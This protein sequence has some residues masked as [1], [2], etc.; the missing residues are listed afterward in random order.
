MYSGKCCKL[1]IWDLSRSVLT[2]Y[3]HSNRGKVS[4]F[5]RRNLIICG[6]S[7]VFFLFIIQVVYF[8][9]KYWVVQGF[10]LLS[11]LNVSLGV[12][13]KLIEIYKLYKLKSI[14]FEFYYCVKTKI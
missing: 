11:K 2:A 9:S 6:F 13:L 12:L 1:F 7:S 8:Y 5:A 14:N 10:F 3:L 4:S